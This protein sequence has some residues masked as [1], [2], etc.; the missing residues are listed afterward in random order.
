MTDQIDHNTPTLAAGKLA[1]T[2]ASAAEAVSMS[3]RTIFKEIAAG[4]L[5][6]RKPSP[7]VT[8]IPAD[9]LRAWLKN[10]PARQAAAAA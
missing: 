9:S 6:A 8:L 5:E 4:R 7:Q 3:E 1:Y 10:L 2:P